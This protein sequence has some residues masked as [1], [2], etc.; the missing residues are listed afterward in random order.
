MLSAGLI[1]FTDI[2]LVLVGLM[3]FVFSFSGVTVWTFFRARSKE[4]YQKI[5]E[6]PLR[7]DIHHE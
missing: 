7:E 1:Y 4:F 5:A 2:P 6:M 3:L